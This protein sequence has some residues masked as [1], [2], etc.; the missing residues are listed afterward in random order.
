MVEVN[1]MQQVEMHLK[2]RVEL[3]VLQGVV[4]KDQAVHQQME[5]VSLIQVVVA[6][7]MVMVELAVL[8]KL[9]VPEGHRKWFIDLAARKRMQAG[10][11]E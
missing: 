9:W 5:Q 4:E 10:I 7:E 1:I 2:L 8:V 6:V 11:N 3:Q